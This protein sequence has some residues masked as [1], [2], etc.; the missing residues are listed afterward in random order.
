MAIKIKKKI[1]SE[2]NEAQIGKTV[3]A[4]VDQPLIARGPADAPDIDGRILLKKPARVGEWVDVRITGA[5]VYDL[6]GEV[7]K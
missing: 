7:V 1:A 5:D 3:R 6:L 4:L 2:Y